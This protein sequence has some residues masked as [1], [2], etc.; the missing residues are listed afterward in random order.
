[1]KVKISSIFHSPPAKVFEDIQ[2]PNIM[3]KIASPI[4][5]YKPII[6]EVIPSRWEAGKE[7]I[8]GL[9]LFK[10][11]PIGRHRIGIVYFNEEK[12][13]AKSDESGSIAKEWTHLMTLKPHGHDN[14]LYTDEIE[15]KAG[16]QTVFVWLFANYFYRHRQRKWKSLATDS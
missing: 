15:I 9:R 2:N 3:I 6:P 10:F 13:E 12:M 11:I 7:Y 14:T 8:V 4:L 5:S 1:M 16:C